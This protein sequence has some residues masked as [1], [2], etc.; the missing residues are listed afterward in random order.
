M[1]KIHMLNLGIYYVN[2]YIIHEADSKTC[3]IIDPGGH[4]DKVLKL[5]GENN[6]TLEAILLTHA[7]FDHVGGVKKL[8]AE[9]GCKVYL[10]KEDLILPETL[11]AG[12]LYYTDTYGEGDILELAGLMVHVIQTPGHTPGSVCLIVEDTMFSGDTLFRHNCGRTDLEGGDPGKMRASLQR[13]A[14]M[15][16]NYTVLPGHSSATT[17]SEEKEYNP[18]LRG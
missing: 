4:P 1:L 12:T 14:A 5:L 9:T 10:C 6:L 17:L 15:E 8:A 18:Y 11:T 2:S 13:L 16:H 7:H 3:C